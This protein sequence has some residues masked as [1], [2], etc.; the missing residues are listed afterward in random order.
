MPSS[1]P[2]P[3][4]R[5][6]T[7]S[8]FG[9]AS[10]TPWRGAT[11]VGHGDR[12][13]ADVAGRLVGEQR[14]QLVGEPAE[15]R[16]VGALVAE[17]RELVRDERVVD[18]VDAHGARNQSERLAALLVAERPVACHH[19]SRG[20]PSPHGWMS[21][22]RRHGCRRVRRRRRR[23]RRLRLV[24]YR[25]EGV[26]Q[27]QE[28]ARRPA[29]RPRRAS[30][31]SCAAGPATSARWA[32]S[33]VDEDFFLLVRVRRTATSGCCSP[34]SPPPPSGRS[35]AR[36]S[37]SSSCPMPDDED[38]PAPAGD[39]GH[40][41]RPRLPAMDM[42]ALLDDFELYPDEMLGDI[43]HRL[44]FGA[45][46]DEALGVADRRER[47]DEPLGR[48]R[49]GSPSTRRARRSPPATSGRRGGPGDADGDVIGRGRNRREADQDP[50]AH[51]EVVALREAA[52]A[53]GR[54]R[55]DGCTLVVTLEPCTM[56]AGA[57]GLAGSG[58]LVFGAFDAKAGAVGSLWDV[59]RDRR[60]NHRPR[61][62]P[63]CSPT[64]AARCSS[65][66]SRAPA[67][68]AVP[69][70][71]ASR[72]PSDGLV[73]SSAVAC[74]S[75]LRRTPRKRLWVK[76]HRGF[77]SLRH[78][79]DGLQTEI[80]SPRDESPS[81]AVSWPEAGFTGR[82]CCV[83]SS[84]SV[85]RELHADVSRR[86][87]QCLVHPVG[88]RSTHVRRQLD[89]SA[90]S[91]ARLRDGPIERALAPAPRRDGEWR[92]GPPR[93]G[94]ARCPRGRG[95]AGRTAAGC[96]TISPSSMTTS[97]CRGS[98]RIASNA[99]QY[100]AGSGSTAAPV[101]DRGGRRRRGRRRRARRTRGRPGSCCSSRS[102]PRLILSGSPG[103]S[104]TPWGGVETHRAAPT[105]SP[106]RQSG[107]LG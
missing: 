88:F 22:T 99:V 75:G 56:C 28:L 69:P 34:T 1:M 53:R 66:S 105:G 81:D 68:A 62:S 72:P 23:G 95:A 83:L 16:R 45:L 98:V 89:D 76:V 36:W 39:L 44:G 101:P 49:C 82:R 102:R 32:W 3:A 78:R 96:A 13:D 31:A 91:L 21:P 55:L 92:P 64:S 59:V 63:G 4:R 87:T 25:E 9:L 97:R 30:P 47:P 24:A 33:S 46:Y 6:G 103:T 17:R 38:D 104:P 80:W 35:P 10:W 20:P 8:G 94:R 12:V 26:W 54:W 100:A 11:G 106:S 51:A 40:R 15:R 74:P 61:W 7:T 73:P 77:K 58:R 84:L 71:G 50:T 85:Q 86:E 2:S 37:R 42:G 29:R 52:P 70:E 48:R 79:Q 93:S 57:I 65:S 67:P 90:A 19:R 27:V 107:S 5:I 14:D 60:L 41:R 18:H 43:A